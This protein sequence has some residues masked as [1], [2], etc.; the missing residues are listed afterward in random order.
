MYRVR[1]FSNKVSAFIGSRLIMFSTAVLLRSM[2]AVDEVA[3]I[4]LALS[5]DLRGEGV[6]LSPFFLSFFFFFLLL[7]CSLSLSSSSVSRREQSTTGRTDPPLWSS[8]A[9][10]ASPSVRG[11][12]MPLLKLRLTFPIALLCSWCPKQPSD[13]DKSL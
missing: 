6:S 8:E 7:S 1:M 9:R 2:T 12:Q 3:S 4:K 11:M 13:T 5:C 10:D